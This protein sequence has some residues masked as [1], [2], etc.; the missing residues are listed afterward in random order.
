MLKYQ[1]MQLS[2][3]KEKEYVSDFGSCKS[4]LELLKSEVS[5]V[6]A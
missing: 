5:V 2:K 6:S 3:A 4:N 1:P